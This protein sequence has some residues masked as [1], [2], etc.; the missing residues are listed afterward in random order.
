MITLLV[1]I[2]LSACSSG[3]V[4]VQYVKVDIKN[5][6]ILFESDELLYMEFACKVKSSI[7]VISNGIWVVN[8]ET[9]AAE[10]I[11]NDGIG[12]KNTYKAKRIVK[13]KNDLYINSYHDRKFI[14]QFSADSRP[15]KLKRKE[16]ESPTSFDDFEILS[17]STLIAANPYWESGFIR[18]FDLTTG[19]IKRIGNNEI[20][21]LMMKFNI[22]SA[23]IAVNKNNA[24]VCQSTKPKIQVVSVKDQAII[25][26]I[27]LSPPFYSAIPSEYK[28]EKYNHKAHK[29]WMSGWTKI[30]D[31]IAHED[32]LLIT[33][34]R[35]YEEKY[36]YE[37]INFNN[38]NK[39]YYI[40]ETDLRI[41]DFHVNGRQID[42]EMVK[43][44]EEK[45]IWLKADL[46]I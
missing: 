34:K 37:L 8:T 29:Q 3:N 36:Y 42:I 43:Q 9:K 14:D 5:E 16:F 10:K 41:F 13:F 4:D 12:P 11:I 31:L 44:A 21:A 24:Y 15:I 22:N 28:V 45:L 2:L 17:D 46:S 1:V 40:T 25:E 39:R 19:S 18:I 6:K 32:W 26:S 23:S 30:Y 20:D 38:K 7:F 27:N 35:G 33:Y